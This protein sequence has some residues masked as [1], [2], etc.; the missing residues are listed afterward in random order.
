MYSS[1]DIPSLHIDDLS[2]QIE[3][4]TRFYEIREEKVDVALG[5][6]EAGGASTKETTTEG[7]EV[8]TADIIY[9][10]DREHLLAHFSAW[11]EKAGEFGFHYD[12]YNF[13]SNP[14]KHFYEQMLVQ[15]NV[16][17]DEVEDIYFTGALTD[18]AKT[19][20]FI[21]YKDDKGKWRRYTPD[22]VI[23]K[24]PKKGGNAAQARSISWRSRANASAATRLTARRAGRRWRSG[25]GKS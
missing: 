13:D 15:L 9:P 7:T 10:K 3:E 12:P 6:G 25:N 8:Y 11:K 18:P 1:E 20:F 22:F 21:E 23:R 17:P 16:K 14:E 2:R 5:V 4:Q 19:D 24:K